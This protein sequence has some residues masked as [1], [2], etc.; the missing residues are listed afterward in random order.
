MLPHLKR[1]SIVLKHPQHPQHTKIQ[2]PTHSY[3]IHAEIKRKQNVH[4]VKQFTLQLLTI[5]YPQPIHILD[6]HL[7]TPIFTSIDPHFRSQRVTQSHLQIS[8]HQGV[9]PNGDIANGTKVSIHTAN[10]P[11]KSH[12]TPTRHTNNKRLDHNRRTWP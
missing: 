11:A 2:F 12:I 8:L 10:I 5:H 9:P 7:I 1:T 4:A 6:I 3:A